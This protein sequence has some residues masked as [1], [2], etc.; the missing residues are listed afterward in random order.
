M[1]AE[2]SM[3]KAAVSRQQRCLV[4]KKSHPSI[5]KGGKEVGA[6]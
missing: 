6:R 4:K 5:R 3:Q 2:K 1:G